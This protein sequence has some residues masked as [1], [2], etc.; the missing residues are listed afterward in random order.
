M[1]IT[2]MGKF[3]YRLLFVCLFSGGM[4]VIRD[5]NSGWKKNSWYNHHFR[6]K[7]ETTASEP[8]RDT[9]R[10]ECTYGEKTETGEP[11]GW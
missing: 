8:E 1:Y 4:L 5:C 10:I 9:V 7:Q 3:L 2:G 6:N 11:C